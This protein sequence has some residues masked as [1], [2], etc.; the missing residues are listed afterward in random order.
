MKPQSRRVIVT[1]GAGLIGGNLVRHLIKD[2]GWSV[3]NIDTLTYDGRF[4]SLDDVTTGAATSH[5][6]KE[7]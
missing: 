2:R 7:S 3:L 6:R 4:N 1:G 5:D